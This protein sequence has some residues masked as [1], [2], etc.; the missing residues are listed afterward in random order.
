M[1]ILNFDFIEH[2]LKMSLPRQSFQNRNMTHRKQHY[3]L[4][5][6]NKSIERKNYHNLTS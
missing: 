1:E 4:P 6:C 3:R 2:N 5:T